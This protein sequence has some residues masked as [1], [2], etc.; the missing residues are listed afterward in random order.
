MRMPAPLAARGEI[1]PIHH[2]PP[3][4]GPIV[5]NWHF[6]KKAGLANLIVNPDGTYLFSGKYTHKVPNKDLEIVIA[7]KSALGGVFLFHYLG[8]VSSGGVQWSKQGQSAILKDDFKTFAGKHDWVGS[9]HFPLDKQ[10]QQQNRAVCAAQW[11]AGV[12]A[13]LG[14]VAFCKQF[15]SAW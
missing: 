4:K 9:Y 10:A 12:L 3:S 13:A 5:V 11:T 15:N 1:T 6:K 2:A 14:N 8:H 7:L